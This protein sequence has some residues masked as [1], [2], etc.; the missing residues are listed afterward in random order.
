MVDLK[1][2]L[3]MEFKE[4]SSVEV[5]R[6]QMGPYGPWY[7]GRVIG[8]DG[9]D[10]TIRYKFLMDSRGKLVVERVQ[11]KNMRPQPP[12]HDQEKKR[13]VAGD[14]AEV[15]DTQCWRVGKVAKVLRKGRLV[16]KFYGF[17]QLKEFNVSCLRTHKLWHEK[18]WSLLVKVQNH[19]QEASH[20]PQQTISN[21]CWSLVCSDPVQAVCESKTCTKNEYV[22][23]SLKKR[24]NAFDPLHEPVSKNQML[25]KN[26]RK[27]TSK[28]VAGVFNSPLVK[29]H[30]LY[31]F[32]QI[33]LDNTTK[34]EQE[35]NNWLH[36]SVQSTEDSN[37]CSV[38]SC[39]LNESANSTRGS[40]LKLNEKNFP[41]SDAESSSLPLLYSKRNTVLPCLGSKLGV[42]IH[43]LELEAYK[44]TVLALYASGPLSWEQESMLTNL[45]LSLH[46]SNDEHLLQLR[47]LLAAQVV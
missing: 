21:Q 18:K 42:D 27:R 9:N 1:K 40:S 13:W 36:C 12:Q 47:N 14:I 7:P 46:I 35:T 41:D 5:M 20:S 10:Y 26:I 25:G 4:G 45:R 11:E 32:H 3:E 19:G 17:I 34:P 22:P 37:E 8:V 16:I 29:N 28:P 2:S 44:S 23:R 38:A 39:S 15:F 24:T 43:N 31:T 30:S 6:E 33:R